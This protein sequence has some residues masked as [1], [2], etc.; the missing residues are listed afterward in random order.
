MKLQPISSQ[1]E[2]GEDQR[3]REL[4]NRL[5]TELQ[6][7]HMKGA[8]FVLPY[9]VEVCSQLLFAFYLLAW[10]FHGLNLVSIHRLLVT[11]RELVL[12]S[13]EKPSASSLQYACHYL[14]RTALH[15]K[16]LR[17]RPVKHA[18][19]TN[20]HHIRRDVLFRCSRGD[21]C[22]LNQELVFALHIRWSRTLSQHGD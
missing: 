2:L 5:L 13:L 19:T 10:K 14:L 8:W 15:N 9:Q 18:T 17:K 1:N 22:A 11:K 20:S 16:N 3:E 12:H 21:D 6:R 7:T 4:K